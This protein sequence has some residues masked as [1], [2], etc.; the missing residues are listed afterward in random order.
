MWSYILIHPLHPFTVIEDSYQTH[1]ATNKSRTTGSLGS[2]TCY[3]FYLTKNIN[4]SD[5]T[6]IT[7][8]Q[9]NRTK[10]PPPP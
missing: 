4:T 6:M 2:C 7:T 5:G 1:G 8:S 3:F 9:P 10:V